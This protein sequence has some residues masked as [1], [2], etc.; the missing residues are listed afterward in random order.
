MYFVLFKLL[1]SDKSLFDVW[2][3][4]AALYQDYE[5]TFELDT[6]TIVLK[7]KIPDV[8]TASIAYH[9]NKEKRQ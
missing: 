8:P 9:K 2:S 6:E 1:S 3:H 5:I 7:R 4:V